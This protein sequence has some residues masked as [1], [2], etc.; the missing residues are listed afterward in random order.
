MTD[1]ND[2]AFE[3]CLRLKQLGKP[4]LARLRRCAGKPLVEASGPA[5]LLFFQLL[6]DEVWKRDREI[7]FLIATL[8]PLADA[9]RMRRSFGATL[10]LIRDPQ[11]PDG[12]DRR[13]RRLLDADAKQLP[14]LL[15]QAVRL[16]KSEEKSIDWQTLL[17]DVLRWE[18]KKYPRSVQIRWA[19][20]YFEK[21]RAR[22]PQQGTGNNIERFFEQQPTETQP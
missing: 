16:L 6:P 21:G 3:F 12:I 20:D 18:S 14:F 11:H 5:L 4:D 15:R 8:F 19:G 13:M 1:E 17:L 7:Y 22:P 10:R 9:S 2:F